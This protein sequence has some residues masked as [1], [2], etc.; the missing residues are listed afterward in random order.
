M[1]KKRAFLEDKKYIFAPYSLQQLNIT[2]NNP[3][4]SCGTLS[5]AVLYI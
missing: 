3:L 1:H 2:K 4:F 5:F